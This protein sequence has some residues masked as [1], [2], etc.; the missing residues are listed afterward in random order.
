MIDVSY[1]AVS[2]GMLD[3]TCSTILKHLDDLA[4]DSRT[5]VCYSHTIMSI[6]TLLQVAFLT[7]DNQL[8]FYNLRAT[9]S[10]PQMLVCP[11]IDDMFK[12]L[13]DDLLV[14]LGESREVVK[15][16]LEALPGMFKNNQVTDSC[17]GTAFLAAKDILSSV[18][19]RI[20]VFQATLPSLGPGKLKNREDVSQRYTA[21]AR[22][23]HRPPQ[24]DCACRGTD[25]EFAGLVAGTDFYKQ[26]SVDASRAQIG[27]D[28]FL[29]NGLYSDLSALSEAA[30]FSSGTCYYYPMFNANTNPGM[31]S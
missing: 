1:N 22:R 24:T 5:Q 26:F 27:I 18:G 12:P 29:F 28:M 21:H 30:K 8:Q 25:K 6:L 15:Q 2:T 14:N 13:H 19:G 7:F 9:L 17:L 16:L 23:A 4:G 31:G 11:D 10:Q 20:M 3:V